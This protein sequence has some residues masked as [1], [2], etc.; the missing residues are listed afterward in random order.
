MGSRRV[1]STMKATVTLTTRARRINARYGWGFCMQIGFSAAF[2]RMLQDFK[3]Y[4]AVEGFV[5]LSAWKQ[6]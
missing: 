5:G 6:S 2:S 4:T 3:F 1:M